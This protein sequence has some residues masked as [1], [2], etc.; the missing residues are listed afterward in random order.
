MTNKDCF[1]TGLLV[2]FTANMGLIALIIELNK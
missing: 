1:L 2:G